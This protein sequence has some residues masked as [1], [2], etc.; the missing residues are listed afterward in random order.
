MHWLAD[1]ELELEL[2]DGKPYEPSGGA[3]ELFRC[4]AK[5]ILIEGPANTG[6]TRA[7]LEKAHIAAEKY[8]GA[9]I[10]F[11]RATRTS[12][13]QSVLVTYEEKV[14]PVGHPAKSGAR[15]SHRESYHYPNGSEVVCGGLD[16]ADRLMS[17]EYDLICLFEATE[18]VED[19]VEK[20]TTR[21]RNKVMP[22]QQ[23]IC[24]CNPAGPLHWL[25]LRAGRGRMV[26][27]L[28]RHEDNPTVD[29]D[30]LERLRSLS[31]A[32]R[33]RLYEGRW[34]A[35]DGL[36]Y[37]N[38][39]RERNVGRISVPPARVLIGV[40]DGYTEPFCA[41]RIE[42]DPDN[43]AYIAAEVY[44]TKMVEPEKVAAIRSLI[45]GTDPDPIIVY[46]SAA[47][48]LGA[49]LVQAGLDAV[50]CEK[51]PD[52]IINGCHKVRQ[53]FELDGT[54]Q[55]RLI[56][57]P[58]C[59]NFLKEIDTYEWSKR[60]DGSQKDKPIDQFNHA[61]D[62]AR[63]AI[64]YIDSGIDPIVAGVHSGEPVVTARESAR[65]FYDRMREADEDFG[66]ADDV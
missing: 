35:A 41:L 24:D 20:L 11:V 48:S 16:N 28:S 61:M 29:A 5:E 37:E 65:G 53:R 10:L 66:F 46:D 2:S 30:Y 15:R 31:G 58:G 33:S 60:Q 18:A 36:V 39:T 34:V 40:D 17:T 1:E 8:P 12:M 25:N 4:R 50:P 57:D 52:S 14:L 59:V 44:Q 63:Y 21:L 45:R 56:V 23:L 22:Y 43:R 49:A 6:K 19:D 3:R 55:P 13:T 47:A 54:G 26:R 62:A 27:I 9:R 32:L 64:A 7:V 38:F 42:L 51:G